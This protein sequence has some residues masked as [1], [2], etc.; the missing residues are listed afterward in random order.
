MPGTLADMGKGK[1]KVWPCKIYSATWQK[2]PNIWYNLEKL[3]NQ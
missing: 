3:L 2:K 1:D